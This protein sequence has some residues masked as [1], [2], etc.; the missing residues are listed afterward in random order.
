M[1]SISPCKLSLERK[2]VYNMQQRLLD[3]TKKTG[4]PIR[5]VNGQRYFG[6]P[7]N[8]TNSKTPRNSEVFIARLPKHSLEDDLYKFCSQIGTVYLIRMM[9][10]H[11]GTSKGFCFVTF[12][13]EDE[14]KM[15]INLLP[16]L[17]F[18]QRYNL[19][20]EMSDENRSIEII[21][22]RSA[23]YIFQEKRVF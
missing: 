22:Y 6:P 14:A 12:T 3:L 20:F 4:Y 11:D 10:N 1:N 16:Q 17:K 5:Q 8:W 9:V 23:K 7:T 15:A 19:S 2:P 13:T 21:N 18:L